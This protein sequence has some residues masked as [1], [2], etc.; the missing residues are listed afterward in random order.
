M[1]F[2]TSYGT[3]LF[4]A[5]DHPAG[6]DSSILYLIRLLYSAAAAGG[7]HWFGD[8]LKGKGLRLQYA[9]LTLSTARTWPAR[10]V[11]K[12]MAAII[13]TWRWHVTGSSR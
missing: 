1:L 2:F 12:Q 11:G 8:R 3:Q 4:L 9:A 6:V 5:H 13:W 10:L 7:D